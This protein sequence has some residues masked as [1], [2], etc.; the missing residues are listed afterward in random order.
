[1][2]HMQMPGLLTQPSHARVGPN[3]ATPDTDPYIQDMVR[4]SEE[5]REERAK[6]RLQDYY[7]RN[8]KVLSSF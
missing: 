5:K 7:K 1:M 4:K 2:A 3:V 6:Q 8:Y